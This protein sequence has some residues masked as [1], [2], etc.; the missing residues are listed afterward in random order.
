[1]NQRLHEYFDYSD[2]DTFKKDFIESPEKFPELNDFFISLGYNVRTEERIALND[3]SKMSKLIEKYQNLPKQNN[4]VVYQLNTQLE[5][6]GYKTFRNTKNED[7]QEMINYAFTDKSNTTAFLTNDGLSETQI[8][9]FIERCKVFNV[10]FIDGFLIDEENKHYESVKGGKGLE[11]AL[12]PSMF[13]EKEKVPEKDMAWDNY[14]ADY[15]K[16]LLNSE[17]LQEIKTQY[18]KTQLSGLHINVD[19]ERI[20]KLL[21]LDNQDKKVEH[22]SIAT[23]DNN[24]RINGYKLLSVGSI[25]STM[26][27][28]QTIANE[29]KSDNVRGILMTH[30]HPSGNLRPSEADIQSTIRMK[31]I[32]DYLDKDVYDHKIVSFSGVKYISRTDGNFLRNKKEINTKIYKKQSELARQTNFLINK[33]KKN[34][35]DR[36]KFDRLKPVAIKTEKKDKYSVHTIQLSSLDR[37][38]AEKENLIIKTATKNFNNKEYADFITMAKTG[39]EWLANDI[40]R[41]AYEEN[42]N[43]NLKKYFNFDMQEAEKELEPVAEV[44]NKKRDNGT[45]LSI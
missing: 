22:L 33:E 5:P 45:N 13:L 36:Y 37:Q 10:N 39:N 30:C 25:N 1:M 9:E 44:L 28:P 17:E 6:V 34:V 31:R 15:Q 29:L 20:D 8:D 38:E 40:F 2:F 26:V 41:R 32:T 27:Y 4:T 35:Y 16:E 24:Y 19:E 23:Y 3:I 12:E 21:K 7:I 43:L 14:I 11:H 42:D 18:V